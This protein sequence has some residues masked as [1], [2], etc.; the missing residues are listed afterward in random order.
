MK[1]L[2]LFSGIGG[3]RL[4]IGSEHECVAYSEIEPNAI[5]VYDK[6]FPKCSNIGDITTIKEK[7]LKDFDMLVGGFPCQSFSIAGH[8][9]G[10]EDKRGQV[11]FDMFRIIETKRPKI[12][13]FE[14]VKGLLSHDKGASFKFIRD[15]L[16]ESGYTLHHEVLNSKYFGLPQNRERLF[17]VG[18]LKELNIT[19]FQFPK[20]IEDKNLSI[21]Q[22][23]EIE[24][25]DALLIQKQI[26]LYKNGKN[27]V[28]I[29]PKYWFEKDESGKIKPLYKFLE[30]NPPNDVFLI[31]NEIPK[32]A[33]FGADYSFGGYY[34]DNK[35]YT[36]ITHSYG[37]ITGNSMKILRDGKLSI[38]SPLECERLQGFPDNWT[39]ILENSKYRYEKIGNAVSIP[40]IKAIFNE[41][42]KVVG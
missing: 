19:N 14:N 17:I 11:I 12:L 13:F 23:K 24:T 35:I 9:K 4:G 36:T 31:E 30:S 3:F 1:Y 41:I 42:L 15:F 32:M 37:R 20:Q 40:V 5:K 16:E 28:R 33:G 8:R 25:N 22:F 27:K 26:G 10:M 6:H 7:E 2:E 29:P 34:S 21:Y 18:F 38:L 39:A